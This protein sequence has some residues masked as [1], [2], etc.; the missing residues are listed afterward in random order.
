MGVNVPAILAASFCLFGCTG[1]RQGRSPDASA[2]VDS[3]QPSC[4]QCSGDLHSVLDCSGTLIRECP[5]DQGCGTDGT[6]VPA[7]QSASEN[8]STIGCEYFA[9]NP[10][11]SG[12]L[13][14]AA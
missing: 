5:P 1:T 2:A 4:R 6:C 9:I 13:C 3:G 12:P 8:H 14:F 7:C 11:G 10:P